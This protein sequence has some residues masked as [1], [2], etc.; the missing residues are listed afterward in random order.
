V[1]QRPAGRARRAFLAASLAALD[2]SL[3]G[4][5]VV[6]SGDPALAVRAVVRDTGAS[7]V[8]ATAD[9]GPYG[10]RRDEQV[11]RGLAE[12]GLGL[13]LVG[14][15]YAVAPG[16]VRTNAGSGYRVFTPFRRAWEREGWDRPGPAVDVEWVE[17]VTG[18]GVPA[19]PALEAELPPAGEPAA[20][21]RAEA[22]LDGPVHAYHER[23]DVPGVDGTSRLSPYLKW[24]VLH[25]RQLLDRLGDDRGPEVFRSELA[26]REFYADVLFHRP[27]SARHSLDPR[28]TT[29]RRDVGPEADRR[30]E[31]WAEG[32]TGYPIVDAGMR[33][34]R[35]EGWMH[36]R[37]RMIV[38]SFLVK[39]L[40]LDWTRGAREFMD[41]LVDGDLASNQHG[42]QWVAGTGT[43]AAPFFRVFN[44]VS[45]SQRFDP[46][47]RYLRRW[48]PELAEVPDRYVHA[49][50]TVPGGPPAGYPGPIVDHDVQRREALARYA[51]V[52]GKR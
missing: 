4:A 3:G 27:E 35:A 20:W 40:H 50:W 44:P 34:L 14:T 24:G 52:T 1:L 2:Q 48:I 33:Q 21:D 45:Q 32:R 8:F 47:G 9:F 13:H 6:R 17:G 43:D 23:R 10:R 49:P 38:G 39:D 28:M 41:H 42:W 7:A 29:L 51:E 46:D 37:V 12:D 26:W 30:F 22:F 19:R 25:P 16:T 36:N 18:D 5:L 11:S 31:A 15:P